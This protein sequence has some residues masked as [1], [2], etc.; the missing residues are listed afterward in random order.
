AASRVKV[1]SW[2]EKL[3]SSTASSA[4]SPGGTSKRNDTR[5][6]SSSC[7]AGV[8]DHT[9]G[10]VSSPSAAAGS[11]KRVLATSTSSTGNRALKVV[12]WAMTADFED[13]VRVFRQ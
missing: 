10:S 1:A 11:T 13:I 8:R 7:G 6:S 12:R 9:V 3:V 5:S 2:A 4:F